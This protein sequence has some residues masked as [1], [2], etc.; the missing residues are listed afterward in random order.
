MPT[1]VNWS[2]LQLNNT[3]ETIVVIDRSRCSNFSTE[4]VTT[5]SSHCDFVLVHEADNIVGDVFH[6]VAGVVV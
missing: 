6:I 5:N 1:V 3:C 4:A 2:T